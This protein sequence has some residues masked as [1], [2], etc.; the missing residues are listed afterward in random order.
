[1]NNKFIFVVSIIMSFIVGVLV[2]YVVI[3][4]Y[5]KQQAKA[6]FYLAGQYYKENNYNY[7]AYYAVQSITKNQEEYGPL[8]LLGNIYASNGDYQLAEQ[9]F[10]MALNKID[11][12]TNHQ[13]GYLIDKNNIQLKLENLKKVTPRRK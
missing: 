2:C 4:A 13:K 6:S 10:K 5:N 7:A 11:N 1:M 3:S 9:M 12:Q 8:Y